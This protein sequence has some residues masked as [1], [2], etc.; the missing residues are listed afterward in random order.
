MA[1]GEAGTAAMDALNAQVAGTVDHRAEIAACVNRGNE[2]LG[3][4][5]RGEVEAFKTFAE[6]KGAEF[7]AVKATAIAAKVEEILNP[8]PKVSAADPLV[9]AVG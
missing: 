9:E 6:S 8:K 3:A 7:Q 2:I 4:I 5:D 1:T